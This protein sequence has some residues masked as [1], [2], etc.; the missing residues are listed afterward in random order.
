MYS[1]LKL[2]IIAIFKNNK[3]FVVTDVTLNVTDVTKCA[4]TVKSD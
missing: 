1:I 3:I 4:S 2:L